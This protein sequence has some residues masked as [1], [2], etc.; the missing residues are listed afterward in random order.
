MGRRRKGGGPRGPGPVRTDSRLDRWLRG[1]FD[2]HRAGN[3]REAEKLARRVLDAAP[4][5]PDALHLLATV[6]RERGDPVLAIDLYRRLLRRHPAIPIAQNSLGNLL[7]ERGEWQEAV[8]CYEAAVTHDPRYVSAY[9]NLGRALL[10]MNDLVR[11]EYCLRQAAALAPGDAQIRA[12]HARALVELGRQEEAMAETLRSVE[13][14]PDSS[15]IRNDAGVVHSTIGDFDA[16]RECYRA[17]LALDPGN[18]KAALNLAKSKRFTAEHDEDADRI[19][20]AAAHGATDKGT[21]RDLHLALGKIHDD[22]GEW[23]SAFTHYEQANRPFTT[24]ALK[25]VETSLALMDRMRAVF[26][27]LWFAARSSVAASDPT[28][29]FVVGMPRSGTS[30]V[31][32]CLAAHPQVYGAGELSAILRLATE[33][34]ARAGAEADPL[35]AG[36]ASMK[37]VMR[38]GA[39]TSYPGCLRALEDAQIAALGERYLDHLRALAPEAARVTDKLPGNYLHLGFI[40]TILPGAR[41][42]HCRRNPLDNAISLYFTDFMAGHEYSNDLYAIGRQI[43][44]MRALMAHWEAVL[45]ARLLTLDYEALTADPEPFVRE[46]VA[47]LGLEW[48]DACLSPHEVARTVRTASAWQVRQPVYRRSAGRARHYERFLDRLRE[49]L[50]ESAPD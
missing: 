21:Q 31:E 39:E 37:A 47:H 45:G 27:A 25:E 28:P 13:L 23:E 9:F 11:A 24:A 17:A 14:D 48:N 35:R 32:Q 16:A 15:V 46:M 40:A 50:G 3:L 2:A 18:A 29:V 4:E 33:A 41:I 26:D 5:Q 36:V 30:L 7:Q 6:A 12:R 8:A 34:A 10:H 43:R 44:G 49:G 38:A 42:I 22:R 20:A 1:A 19:R